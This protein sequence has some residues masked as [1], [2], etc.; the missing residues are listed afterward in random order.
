VTAARRIIL[1]SVDPTMTRLLIANVRRRGFEVLPY[2]SAACCGLGEVPPPCEAEIFLTDLHCPAPEC[3]D[4]GPRLRGAHPDTPLLLLAHERPS[5]AYLQR[6]QPCDCLEKP[7][8]MAEALRAIEALMHPSH[9][10]GIG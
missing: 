9:E 5:A 7:F 2:A 3:W 8:G 6:H 4:A 10:Q 1:L